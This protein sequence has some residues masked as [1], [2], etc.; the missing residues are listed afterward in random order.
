MRKNGGKAQNKPNTER[1]RGWLVGIIWTLAGITLAGTVLG[2]FL[3]WRISN[4]SSRV[5]PTLAEH[6]EIYSKEQIDKFVTSVLIT[7]QN[8]P[9]G[10]ENAEAD[11]V[12]I[13]SFNAFE[14]R[15]TMVALASETLL[16]VEN[17]GTKTLGEIYALG[18]P[19]LLANA[20]NQNFDLDLQKYACTDTNALAAMLDLLGGAQAELTPEEAEYIRDALGDTGANVQAGE[21]LLTGVQSMVHAMDKRSGQDRLG[22]LKRSVTLVYSVVSNMRKTAT[23]E[24]MLPLLSLVFSSIQTNL[25][26]ETLR[27]LGYEILQA[28]EIEY[29]RMILPCEGSFR[30]SGEEGALEI[31]MPR[32]GTLLRETLYNASADM[33]MAEGGG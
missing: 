4:P 16:E 27:E 13:A 17:H 22:N 30:D 20:M 6:V 25:D 10:R 33:A 19:T 8:Q 3:V 7:V 21:V 2:G 1:L 29:D 9:M 28:E 26:I 15:L 14:Q 18:G 24:A 5:F 12:F 11:M 23:K 32:N 31:D